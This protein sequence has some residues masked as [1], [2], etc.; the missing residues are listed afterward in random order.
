MILDDK[1]KLKKIIHKVQKQGKKVLIKKGVFD[2]IH[3]GHIYALSQFKKYADI[4]IIFVQSDILTR[5]KKGPQRP[6]NNQKYR[7][8]ALDGLKNIDYIYL[9]KSKSREECLSLLEYLKPNLIAIVKHDQKKTK[10]Y[11]RPYWELKEFLDKE[12][13]SFSTSL[14]IKKIIKKYLPR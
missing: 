8:E 13:K 2:I 12:K 1:E 4:V 14:I 6:I 10:K 5:K 3:P 9:D 11:A 7:A